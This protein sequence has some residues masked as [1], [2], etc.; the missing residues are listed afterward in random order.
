[1]DTRLEPLQLVRQ[2]IHLYEPV[3]SAAA[4]TS[5]P[6]LVILCTWLGGA[7]PR[8]INKYVA[9]Y[10]QM[11]PG[12]CILLLTTTLPDLMFRS[13]STLRNRLKP[14]GRAIRR[15]LA[16]HGSRGTLLHLF[17][18]GG[19]NIAVQ[20]ALSLKEEED[21]GAAFFSSLRGI[22]L[23][24]CPGDDTLHRA[25]GAARMSVP[26]TAVAQVLE[27]A[28]LSPTLTVVNRLQ[29]AGVLRSVRD[30]RALLLDASIFGTKPR[31][32]YIYSKEDVMVGWEDVQMH[33]EDARALGYSTQELVFEHGQ[34]CG[35]VME[36]PDRYWTTVQRFWLGESFESDADHNSNTSPPLRSR[37]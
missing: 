14:A 37:L 6:A 13:F 32:L 28:F 23:D 11:Y 20:L 16:L 4:P 21:A 26:Q 8:R 18:H 15:V 12:A 10:R 2:H 29:H 24:C 22:I 19:G 34:H 7:T 9:Q 31:R 33:V 25:I 5:S 27:R 17:S 35:L 3:S 30:L 1:M 36:D